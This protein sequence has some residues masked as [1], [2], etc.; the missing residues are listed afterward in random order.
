MKRLR[1]F[2]PVLI[3]AAVTSGC[4]KGNDYPVSPT[5]DGTFTGEFRL[6][7]KK[8]NKTT[9]DTAKTIIRLTLTQ[10]NAT[11]A[12]SGDTTVVHAASK[13]K[14]GI[15]GSL[16]GFDDNTL[17]AANAANTAPIING[18]AHLNGIY[19]FAY[20]GSALQMRTIVG[21]TIAYEYD[22]KKTN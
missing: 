19:Q 1:Y 6:I 22:L 7:S 12:I 9:I 21:D 14:Y 13:G 10:A 3:G 15:N 8:A 20:N 5:P 2:I 11:F 18:K 16:I 4:L 17:S